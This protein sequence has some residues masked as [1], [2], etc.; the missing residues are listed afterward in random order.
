MR[1]L[2][3][4][5]IGLIAAGAAVTGGLAAVVPKPVLF[6]SGAGRFEVAA[7]DAAGAQRVVGLA[8][9]AWRLL[10]GPL[11]L[12]DSFPSPVFVRL[13]PVENWDDGPPFRVIVEA[14]GVVSVRVRW[15]GAVANTHVRRALVQGLLMRQ[16]V[17]RHGVRE[18]LAVPLWLEHACAGWW[19][20]RAEPAQLDALKQSSEQ[21]TPPSLKDL[22]AWQRGATEPV[23]MREGSVWLLTL[24]V[25]E[26]SRAGEWPAMLHRL[27]GGE[28]PEVAL[29]ATFPGHFADETQRELWWLTAWHHLCRVR[30]LPSLEA[31]ESHAELHDLARFVFA[32]D[33]VDVVVPLAEVIAHASE[34]AVDAELKRRAAVL[35][36]LLPS[37]HPFYRNA[38]LSLAEAMAARGVN[39]EKHTALVAAFESDW[40]DGTEIATA[41]TRLLDELERSRR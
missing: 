36:H 24:L 7:V 18:R 23:E 13:V 40:R 4:L 20:T 2:R 25:G 3:S 6:Q 31:A 32:R 34:V 8:E 16:A 19:L 1:R 39:A 27:L 14:G 29:A 26:N 15:D 10:T 12:P 41:S 9:E 33:G 22:L 17:A 21:H 35:N 28:N 37:M 11:F 5:I 38:A 30:V